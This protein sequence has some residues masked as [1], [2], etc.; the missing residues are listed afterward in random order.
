MLNSL[1]GKNPAWREL[2]IASLIFLFLFV[3]FLL[4]TAATRTSDSCPGTL[5]FYRLCKT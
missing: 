4:A 5:D 2:I 1:N 3:Y